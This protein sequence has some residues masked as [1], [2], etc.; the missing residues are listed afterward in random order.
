VLAIEAAA[1][2]QALCLAEVRRGEVEMQNSAFE[3]DVRVHGHSVKEF[4]HEGKTYIEG[5]K[6]SEFTI[7]VV[8]R[9][10]KSVLAVV[11]VDGLSVMDG[12]GASYES[13]GYVLSPFETLIIPGWRLD[14]KNV[15]KFLFTVAGGSYAAQVDKPKNVGVIGCAFFAEKE[16]PK[17]HDVVKTIIEEH[18]HYHRWP[19]VP[20]NPYPYVPTLGPVWSVLN[21]TSNKFSD[22][23]VTFSCNAGQ[24][25][26]ANASY[27]KSS[28]DACGFVSEQDNSV[29]QEVGTGF[30]QQAQHSVNTVTF[31]REDH[32]LQVLEV[33]YDSREA[34]L[35]RG[36]DLRP[37][38]AV[39]VPQAFPS[40]FC[41]PPP[42]WSK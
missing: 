37:K 30:G 19:Y 40:A 22:G 18:H 36:I 28:D 38:A 33:L 4:L 23:G 3:L 41:T 39:S 35:K 5:R 13:G 14:T 16:L 24:Q 1:E 6:G 31:V 20:Y 7:R 42:G 34:L 26:G 17:F 10:P 32:P 27:L 25:L 8:N 11:S 21:S 12:K 9:S 15:A 2:V 29:Q